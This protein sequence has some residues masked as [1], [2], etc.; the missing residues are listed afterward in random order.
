MQLLRPAELEGGGSRLNAAF[1]VHN[2][3]TSVATP[4]GLCKGLSWK[5]KKLTFVGVREKLF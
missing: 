3:S 5:I 2:L 4:G 1:F